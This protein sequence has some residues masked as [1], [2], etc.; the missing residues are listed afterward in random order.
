M[1]REIRAKGEADDARSAEQHDG[2][3]GAVEI[4]TKCAADFVLDSLS[5]VAEEN[6]VLRQ[7]IGRRGR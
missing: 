1:P 4:P 6:V 7:A 5:N 2:S 3:D